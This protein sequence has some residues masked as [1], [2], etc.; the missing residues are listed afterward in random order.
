MAG[1]GQPQWSLLQPLHLRRADMNYSELAGKKAAGVRYVERVR[2]ADRAGAG[3]GGGSQSSLPHSPLR[4]VRL[5][6]AVLAVVAAVA[7]CCHQP[8]PNLCTSVIGRV[9]RVPPADDRGA[10]DGSAAS[11]ARLRGVCRRR[12]TIG[13]TEDRRRCGGDP[14]SPDLSSEKMER[15]LSPSRCRFMQQAVV[16]TGRCAGSGKRLGAHR[17]TS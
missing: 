7:V 3:R 16:P 6:L 15:R 13:D 12:A 2:P 1:A 11:A 14:P 4:G 8:A 10:A 17:T 5:L 9:Y